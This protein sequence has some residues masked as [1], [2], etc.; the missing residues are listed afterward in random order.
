VSEFEHVCAGLTSWRIGP[1]ARKR[2]DSL[3]VANSRVV[4]SH[5]LDFSALLALAG[6]DT[7]SLITL[8][9]T[10]AEQ[11]AMTESRT[12]ARFGQHA[13]KALHGSAVGLNEAPMPGLRP[14][15]SCMY[16]NGGE[17]GSV[18]AG[19]AGSFTWTFTWHVHGPHGRRP[20]VAPYLA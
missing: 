14:G 17:R 19:R 2:S 18:R 4:I 8:R 12:S 6:H 3:E 13:Q 1:G 10:S 5:D 9:L 7:P 20:Q 15:P 16:P 11:L